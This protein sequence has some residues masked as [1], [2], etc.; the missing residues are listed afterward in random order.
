LIEQ[1]HG[2]LATTL[3]LFPL[4]APVAMITRL[5]AGGIPLWQP[6][7]GLVGLAVTA[8][9]FVLLAAR[10]FRADTLLSHASLNWQRLVKELRR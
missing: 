10:L 2:N 6:V 8:Y 7:A 3:S 4:T 9:L 1:P 5:V